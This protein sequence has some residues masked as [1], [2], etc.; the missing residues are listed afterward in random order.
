LKTSLYI[1]MIHSLEKNDVLG[2]DQSD[3]EESLT[4]LWCFYSSQV[5]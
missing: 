4:Y 1:S 3:H 5:N 2:D